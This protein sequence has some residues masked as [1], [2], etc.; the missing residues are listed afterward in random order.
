MIKSLTQLIE[1]AK[2]T[3][4]KKMLVVQAGDVK[5]LQGVKKA[6]TA[7]IIEGVLVGSAA[8]IKACAAEID[9]QIK[10]ENIIDADS[11]DAAANLGMQLI[12]AKKA[13]FL[14]K[15][16]IGTG[17]LLK[18]L[19]NKEY[20]LRGSN[21]LSHL[22][23]MDVG[24]DRLVVMTD[25]AMNIAPD[26]EQKALIVQNAVLAMQKLGIDKPKVAVLAAVETVNPQMQAT[27]DAACLS[28]MSQRGQ[29]K[30]AIIDGPLALD[31]AINEEAA[32]QKGIKSEVA[33]QADILLMPAIEA[34]NVFY[35]ALLYLGNF[36]A[37]SV[38]CGAKVPV[39]LTSRADDGETKMLSIALGKLIAQ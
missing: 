4:V 25:G 10:S 13:D 5:V 39:V 26:L 38:V 15:G 31:N 20:Q 21:L 6:E 3:P 27:I 16:L 23:L 9:Y 32:L 12:Q 24:L 22:S 11:D 17:S 14:M 37:A 28:K 34:G 30:D 2:T 35:K 29:I 33:G 19:L 18:A 7:G 1:I 36:K 8:K